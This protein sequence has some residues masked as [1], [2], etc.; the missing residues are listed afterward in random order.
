MS[1]PTKILIVVVADNSAGLLILTVPCKINVWFV[2]NK[3]NKFYMAFVPCT[4]VNGIDRYK[5]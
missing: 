2:H 4:I 3:T 5:T 1:K